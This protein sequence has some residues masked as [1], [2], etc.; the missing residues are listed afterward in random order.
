MS[1]TEVALDCEKVVGHPDRSCASHEKKSD[2][3]SILLYSSS[4]SITSR[5][6]MGTAETI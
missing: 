4:Q 2:H 3:F 1:L 6:N 5:R